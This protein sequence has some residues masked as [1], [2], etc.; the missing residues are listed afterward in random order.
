MKKAIILILISVFAFGCMT[1]KRANRLRSQLCQQTS[2]TIIK[3]SLIQIP[4]Y[5]DD[6]AYMQ[7]YFACDSIGNVY[8]KDAIYFK[9]KYTTLQ[10]T[11]NNNSISVVSKVIVKDTVYKTVTNTIK[12][13][14]SIVY[15]KFEPNRYQNFIMI[16]FW[17][18]LILIILYILYRLLK[19]KSHL[20]GL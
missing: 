3:D 11:L 9:G 8:Q 19:S 1:E 12:E 20:F 2:T 10:S 4:I 6:S 14:G 5:F 18:E 17:I 13:K 16:G 15:K 7:L